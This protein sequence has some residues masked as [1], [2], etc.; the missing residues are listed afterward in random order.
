MAKIIV[1]FRGGEMYHLG[2][3]WQ[4]SS[5]PCNDEFVRP[6]TKDVV[7]ELGSRGDV[8][9]SYQV[10][11]DKLWVCFDKTEGTVESLTKGK[12]SI[13]V[14]CDRAKL[15]GRECAL[16]EI[17]VT[18][19]N[20]EKTVGRLELLADAAVETTYAAGTYIEK[21]GYIAMNADGFT[22]KK[23]VG[24]EGFEVI[25]YLGRMGSAVKAFPVT[26]SWIDAAD[27]PYLRYTF[28]AENAA[29]YIIRFYLLPRNPVEKGAR[30]CLAYAI[31]GERRK[32][33][34]TISDS[35]H[36]DC[37]CEEWNRGVLDNIRVVES[38]ISVKKGENQLYFYAADPGIVLERIVLYPEYTKLPESYLGPIESWRIGEV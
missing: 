29:D 14:T 26:K 19:A 10:Q 15:T 6:D 4:D 16:V 12:D 8:D 30:M 27:A 38:V 7:I 2:V 23:D 22:E 20:G 24:D 21:Q 13:V 28:A 5:Y 35:F 1:G 36:T 34:D 18:F 37:T 11:C 33:L 31:N 3:H 9:F 17:I 25:A 32:I